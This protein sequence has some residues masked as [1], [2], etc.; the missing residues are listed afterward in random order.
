MPFWVAGYF[1]LY[2][3]FGAYSLHDDYRSY[4]HPFPRM[5]ILV[6]S[7]I[8]LLLPAFS[9]WSTVVR[10]NFGSY[11]LPT[12]VFG[13]ALFVILLAAEMREH[14]TSNK[15]LS[16]KEKAGLGIVSAALVLVVSFPVL[17]WGFRAVMGENADA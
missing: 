12:F 7:D 6:L 14:V 3:T 1:A 8:L 9:Y 5:F 2:F 11:I 17:L 10:A 13:L 16:A 15:S 4:P